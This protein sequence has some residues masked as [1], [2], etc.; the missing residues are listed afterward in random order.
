LENTK[1]KFKI[2]III[3]PGTMPPNRLYRVLC[4]LS[5]GNV[6]GGLSAL[7]ALSNTEHKVATCTMGACECVQDAHVCRVDTTSC[8]TQMTQLQLLQSHVCRV[9]THHV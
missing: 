5:F 9:D 2:I 8:V 6:N 7:S 3:T 1:F 4:I